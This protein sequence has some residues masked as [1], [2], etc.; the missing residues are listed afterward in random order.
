[1][2]SMVKFSMLEKNKMNEKIWQ[3]PK[4]SELIVTFTD[5]ID[6]DVNPELPK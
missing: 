6:E 4:F 3:E 2:L 1:M 5:P